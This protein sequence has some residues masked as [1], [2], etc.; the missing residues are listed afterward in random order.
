MPPEECRSEGTPSLG[1]GPDAWG[2]TFGSFGALAKGT[3]RKGETISRHDRSN[4][5]VHRTCKRMVGCQDA[6]AGKPAP[7]QKADPCKP[8]RDKP[9]IRPEETLSNR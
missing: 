8:A 6:F 2:E 4:G 7:T 5:Y 3:R 1:E 9:T